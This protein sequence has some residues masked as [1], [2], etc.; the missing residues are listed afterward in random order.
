M[1]LSNPKRPS[2]SEKRDIRRQQKSERRRI[3]LQMNTEKNVE[4]KKI[5][6]V[7]ENK[8]NIPS[9]FQSELHFTEEQIK[10]LQHQRCNKFAVACFGLRGDRNIGTI[11]R[12]GSAVG[13]SEFFLFGDPKFDHRSCVGTQHHSDIH[14]VMR[15]SGMEDTDENNAVMFQNIMIGRGFTPI[16]IEQGGENLYE[17]PWIT[18]GEFETKYCLVFGN[19]T[20]GIPP[21]ILRMNRTFF[22]D[23]AILTVPMMGLV[24]SLNVAVTAGMVM[25]HI[26]MKYMKM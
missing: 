1:L 5:T 7:P 6:D 11:I 14:Y 19:E 20:D 9:L 26:N 17:Y 16:F 23:S 24:R 4:A 21:H 3:Y 8:Y 15:D 10:K 22:K 25:S 13:C 2:K 12:T 18:N